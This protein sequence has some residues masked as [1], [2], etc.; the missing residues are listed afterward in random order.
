MITRTKFNLFL[1][2]FLIRLCVLK[3]GENLDKKPGLHYT[4]ID[5]GVFSDGADLIVSGKSPYDRATY[6]YSPLLSLMLTPNSIFGRQFGKL[7]FIL[8]DSLTGFLI[9]QM[10]PNI[11]KS[12][13]ILSYLLWDF[14]PFVINISTRGNSDSI[15]CF[16]L[17][18]TL[19]LLRKNHLFLC[20]I[21]YGISVHL[22]LFPI[23]FV[24]TFFIFLKKR[25][26]LFGIISFSVFMILNLVFY[27]QYGDEFLSETF[28]Y[29]LSRIDYKH[30]F[31]AISAGEFQSGIGMLCR[32]R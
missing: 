7:L 25:V 12:Q 23:F 27:Y 18:F 1:A 22:R 8:F 4:D 5:Y 28:L 3:V 20:A 13:M 29:H 10:T 14:N 9:H 26:F 2:A 31:R 32:R 21:I 30:N 16:L 19:F 15:T 17:V 6:R 11:S 24:F